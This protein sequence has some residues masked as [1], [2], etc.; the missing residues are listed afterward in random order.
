MFTTA[1]INEEPVTDD[2]SQFSEWASPPPD[3]A[4]AF[5]GLPIGAHDRSGYWVRPNT[6]VAVQDSKLLESE[7]GR[8][9][10][11][12][13]YFFADKP[14]A[15]CGMCANLNKRHWMGHRHT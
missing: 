9:H 14:A 1:D 3:D 5:R 12:M 13:C 7:N 15:L 2:R 6:D 11:P 10:H 8:A 4:I